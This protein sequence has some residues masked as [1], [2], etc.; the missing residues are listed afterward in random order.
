MGWGASA[1]A[2]IAAM[3]ATTPAQSGRG[4]PPC[5]ATTVQP[6]RLAEVAPGL[7]HQRGQREARRQ[8]GDGEAGDREARELRQPDDAGK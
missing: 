8:A 5:G 3:T 1:M 6:L 7:I 2:A 4:K